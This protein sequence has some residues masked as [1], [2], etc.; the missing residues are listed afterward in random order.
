MGKVT[1]KPVSRTWEFLQGDIRAALQAC[2]NKDVPGSK[3][4]FVS[5]IGTLGICRSIVIMPLQSPDNP[6]EV[7]LNLFLNFGHT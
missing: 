5:V 7:L 2:W 4:I 1:S 6:L 3:A